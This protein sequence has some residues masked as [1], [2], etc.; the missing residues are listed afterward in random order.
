[1]VSTVALLEIELSPA[2]FKGL[3]LHIVF[4][5]LPMLHDHQREGHGEILGKLAEMVDA[6]ALK[7]LLDG[8]RFELRDVGATYARLTSG[9]AL[10]KIVV[11]V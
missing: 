4:M 3:S 7:P 9:Q 8:N 1:M 10:G 11:E 6:D 2:H 5:L